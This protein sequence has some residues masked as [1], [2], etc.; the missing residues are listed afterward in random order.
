MVYGRPQPTAR[1]TRRQ[2]I[3]ALGRQDVDLD[4]LIPPAGIT[5]LGM[6]SDHLVLDVGDH[7]VT[8]GD[9][10]RFGLGYGALVR[11]MTSPFVTRVERQVLATPDTLGPVA[12]SARR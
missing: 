12:G 2:A 1:G 7:P 10:L 11:A 8:V 9:E 5:V 4:G 6:S 3:V